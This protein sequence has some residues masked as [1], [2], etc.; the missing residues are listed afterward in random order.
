MRHQIVTHVDGQRVSNMREMATI[1]LQR[2]QAY[3]AATSGS[4]VGFGA[5]RPSGKG[6]RS[7]KPASASAAGSERQADGAELVSGSGQGD[8]YIRFSM[9]NSSMLLLPLEDVQSDTRQ[10]LLVSGCVMDNEKCKPGS[11]GV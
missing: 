9:G 8:D 7:S 5:P 1:V 4:G 11:W 6:Q 10:M 2:L 3:Q